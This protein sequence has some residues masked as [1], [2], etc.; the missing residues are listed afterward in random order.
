MISLVGKK[1]AHN[2]AP[3]SLH[4]SGGLRRILCGLRRDRYWRYLVG[5]LKAFIDDSGSGGDSPWVVLAGYIA[6]ADDWDGFQAEWVRVLSDYPRIDCFHASEAESLRPDGQWSG[7]SKTE[8]DKKIDRLIQVIQDFKL[9]PI[10]VRM[11]QS[12][13]ERQIKGGIPRYWDDPYFVLLNALIVQF[14]ILIPDR[15]PGAGQ[16]ELVFDNHERFR[17]RGPQFYDRMAAGLQSLNKTISPNI[18]YENDED[19]PGLQAADLLAWQIRRAFSVTGEPRRRHYDEAR[20]Q[21]AGHPL[22]E[23]VLTREILAD[24][25]RAWNEYLIGLVR[26][27]GFDP[28]KLV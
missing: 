9:Q 23:F 10:S 16:I 27:L 4:G 15:F 8:R 2:E 12:E 14:A 3:Q 19:F 6:R 24:Y 1:S 18:H 5:V 21:Q 20:R 28:D 26:R 11:R 13:Y 25:M 7:V 22:F 17:K